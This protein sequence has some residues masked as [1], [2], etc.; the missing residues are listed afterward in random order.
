MKIAITF[1][2]L[3]TTLFP[4]II[5]SGE[6]FGCI[7]LG[8][9]FIGKGVTIEIKPE[10]KTQLIEI[11]ETDVNLLKIKNPIQTVETQSIGTTKTD[12]CGIYSIYLDREGKHIINMSYE[13]NGEKQFIYFMK[14]HN[15]DIAVYLSG[16]SV[17]YDFIIENKDGKYFAKIK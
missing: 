3:L 4:S 14:E 6:I 11:I 2:I 8:K 12:E 1:I 10:D 5:Y 16:E 17:Q 13:E 15:R 9:K 7:K